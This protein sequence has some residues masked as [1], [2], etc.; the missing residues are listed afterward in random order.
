MDDT[1]FDEL[2]KE[3]SEDASAFLSE[4]SEMKADI[5]ISSEKPKLKK[6]SKTDIPTPEEVQQMSDDEIVNE[7]DSETLDM[8][9]EFSNFLEMK[10]DILPD[11][12]VKEVA[13]TGVDILDAILGGGFAIGAFNIVVGQ[14]GS[15][16]SMIAIQTIGNM[17]HK[18]NTPFTSFLDSEEATTVQR[19]MK[20]GV[21]KPAIKPYTDITIEKIFKFIEGLCIFKEEK[22]L[23]DM[24]AIVVWD[25]IANTL[26]Q[27]ERETDDVNSVIGYKARLL[28]ILVPKYVS[29][30][31][32]Y[33][34]CLL[35]VNQLRDVL[36][37]GQFAP[38]RDLKF[39]SSTKQMPG[40][41]VLKFNAFHL[42]E[43]KVKTALKPEK[44][45]FE[46]I[47]SKVK[48]VKNKLFRPNVEVEIVGDF[49]HGF[50]NFWTNY[51][52]LVETKRMKTGAWNSLNNLSEVK[53]RTKEAIE[54]YKTNS[55]FKE[56]F[57]EAAK[58]A[59][60]IDIIEKY[61]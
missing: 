40:G 58:D 34:I 17:Q 33:N 5:E 59:I 53:F 1:N 22:K 29:K 24:P 43:M 55:K 45:G 8:F 3:V 49:T 48:C 42:V 35:A 50:T 9:N 30:L 44:Y 32:N 27:K 7:T 46:G 14:P 11:D 15:G 28:S 20:L 2:N 51:N 23:V 21:N 31:A 16:K 39:M 36:A 38:A 41:N 26:S 61:N 47:I 12:G 54:M 19:L 25:S 56:A 37:M 13:P 18:Y 52:F 60:K 10:T 4:I 57:D 6:K